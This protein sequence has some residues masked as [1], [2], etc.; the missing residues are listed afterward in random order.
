MPTDWEFSDEKKQPAVT[1]QAASGSGYLLS[2][3]VTN[4][5]AAL[6]IVDPANGREVEKKTGGIEVAS[7][8][9]AN[10]VSRL[11]DK[12]GKQLEQY[13]G[14]HG[15]FAW[16]AGR[17]AYGKC[18]IEGLT[19]AFKTRPQDQAFVYSLKRLP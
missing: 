13:P 16:V 1:P 6:S 8:E 19:V 7:I 12:D 14:V 10:G 11:L 5:S 18:D 4:P 15:G 2:P 3:D 9:T 17:G